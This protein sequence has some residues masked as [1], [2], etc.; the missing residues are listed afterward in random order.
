[1]NAPPTPYATADEFRDAGL[2]HHWLTHTYDPAPPRHKTRLHPTAA[3]LL[4]RYAPLLPPRQA[5]S[6]EALGLRYGE[7]KRQV[8]TNEKD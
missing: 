5:T 2:A 7:A 6:R 4:N 8:P 3:Q 1:M